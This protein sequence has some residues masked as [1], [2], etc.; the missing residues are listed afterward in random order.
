MGES[1]CDFV[2]K[3]ATADEAV[4]K[5]MAHA[6]QAHPDKVKEMSAKMSKEEMVAMMQKAVKEV[7]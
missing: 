5:M 6:I 3:G 1:G 7:V 2:A 4:G